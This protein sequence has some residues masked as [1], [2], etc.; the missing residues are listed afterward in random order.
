MEIKKRYNIAIVGGGSTWTPG[1]LKSLCKMSNTFPLN[2]V[3]M[4]DVVEERQRLIGEFGKILF[5]E[6]YPE[7][8]LEYTTNPDEA[9]IDVDFVFVQMRTGG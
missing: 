2:K 9:F 8:T 1:L 5:K 3:T 7:A 6:E 4:L